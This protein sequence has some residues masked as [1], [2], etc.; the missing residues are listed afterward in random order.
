[1]SAFTSAQEA[2]TQSVRATK[3]L[4]DLESHS[5]SPFMHMT[6]FG[7]HG[8]SIS[9]FQLHVDYL[10][11]VN[12]SIAPMAPIFDSDAIDRWKLVNEL[13]VAGFAPRIPGTKQMSDQFPALAALAAFPTLEEIARRLANCWDA[14]GRLC[15][16]ITE[17]D[18]VTLWNNDGTETIKTYKEKQRIVILSNKLQLAHQTLE[19][20]LRKTIESLDTVLRRSMIEG[21]DAPMSPLYVRLQH[22]R[23]S[24]VHGRR[25][26]GWEALLLS[27]YISLLYFG[28]KRASESG[29]EQSDGA[30]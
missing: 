1:M 23:D 18:G 28:I 30:A 16:D 25:F 27:L 9:V 29:K 8:Y 13:L 21:L 5:E 7:Y 19:P 26:D 15:R 2:F 6:Q 20:R 17:R 4:L 10:N 3:L 24:W 12:E 14:D 11:A 22:Y